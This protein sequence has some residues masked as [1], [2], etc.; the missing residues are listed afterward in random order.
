MKDE[1]N[2]KGLGQEVT[3]NTSHTLFPSPKRVIT[4]AIDGMSVAHVRKS[5]TIMRQA[6]QQH[7]DTTPFNTSLS[8]SD[9]QSISEFAA[10][11]VF[12]QHLK[13]HKKGGLKKRIDD[14]CSPS[15]IKQKR[16]NTISRKSKV[17]K[18]A[19]QHFVK[20]AP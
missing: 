13:R 10:K 20:Q 15:T 18:T 1:N 2:D 11:F 16:R 9:G 7:T 19:F 3:T 5:L 4:S 17:S 14:T 6:W 8:V 12:G